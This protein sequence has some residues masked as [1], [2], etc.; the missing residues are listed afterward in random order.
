[1]WLCIVSFTV[2][3][4]DVDCDN[5]VTTI[6]INVCEGRKAEN[7]EQVL[8]KYFLT[9]LETIKDQKMLTQA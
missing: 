5:P 6:D 9:A 2:Y 8:E 3:S 1:V 4:N 7:A